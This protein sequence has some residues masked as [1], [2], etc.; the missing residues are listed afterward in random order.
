MCKYCQQKN[1]G[2]WLGQARYGR[3]WYL[4]LHD[5]QKWL[6]A[7]TYNHERIY[8]PIKFCP[9]CGQRL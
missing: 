4:S 7:T 2:S 3:D 9:H 8:V 5:K 6:I 1:D